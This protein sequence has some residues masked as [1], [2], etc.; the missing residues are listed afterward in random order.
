VGTD[1]SQQ[2]QAEARRTADAGLLLRR[3]H[4]IYHDQFRLWFGIRAPT[5][6]SAGT[7]LVLA[8]QRIRAIFG[9]IPRGEIGSHFTDVLAAGAI[10]FGGFFLSWLFGT[11][12][13]AAIATIVGELEVENDGENW[14]RD[15]YQRAREHMEAIFAIA[16]VT[17]CLFL[18]G[19]VGLGFV[20]S[21][22][23]RAFGRASFLPYS[24]AFGVISYLLIASVVGWLGASIPLVLTGTRVSAALKR[25]ME[26]SGGYEGALFFLVTESV[27]GSFIAWYV[28]VHGLPL[29]LPS[30]LT[31]SVWYVWILNLVGV[32]ASASVEPPLFIGF[33]LLAAPER[34]LEHGPQQD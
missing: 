11:F 28:V 17:F 9:S 1:L 16:V 21:A 4:E 13:L 24:Y 10:R 31:Y 34:F 6:V 14:S 30:S 12:A 33:S 20:E 26:L 15:S 32:L 5:S 23:I 3:V 2:L 29:I 19:I 8:D 27:A 25:S 7:I 22:A 18:L